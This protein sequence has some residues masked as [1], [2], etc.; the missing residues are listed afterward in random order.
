MRPLAWALNEA[1][2]IGL[3][4]LICDTLP[5]TINS[6]IMSRIAPKQNAFKLKIA[7]LKQKSIVKKILAGR[8]PTGPCA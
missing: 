4:A 8:W 7:P 2:P 5:Y 6:I 3:P 1:D